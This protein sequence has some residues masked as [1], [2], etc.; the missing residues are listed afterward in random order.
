M[1]HAL[2]RVARAWLGVAYD[3]DVQAPARFP[4]VAAVP[5]RPLYEAVT[6]V[7]NFAAALTG[8]VLL[9]PLLLLIA[10]AVK[11][12][13][14]GPALYRG[15][16]VGKDQRVFHIFKFRTM[17]VDAEKRIGKRLVR[18]D[19]NHYTPIGRFLRKYRLDELAQLF[20]VLKGDMN[21][22]G[23]RPMRPIFLEDL[24]KTVPGYAK[25]FAVRPGITGLAQVR[26]GYYTHPRH[27][28]F[29]DV[30]YIAG[31]SVWVDLQ[32][33][34]LTFL[35]V[36]TRIFT[37][38]FLL[39]WLV[40]MALVLPA[41]VQQQFVLRVAKVEL[42][43]LYFVPTLIAVWHVV[44]R[45]VT[46]G[47]LYALRTPLD[48]PLL[49]FVLVTA[50]LVPFSRFPMASLRGLVWYV[51]NGVVVFYVVLNSSLVRE[52]RDTL[53]STL[54]GAT[55][56]MGAIA[57]ARMLYT[58][59]STGE[60]VR[61]AGTIGNPLLLAGLVVLVTPLAAA[62]LRRAT[63][64]RRRALYL[65]MFLPLL[66]TGVLT[67]SRSG[68]LALALGLG[69]YFAR[70]R[71]RVVA[72]IAGLWLA[73]TVAMSFAGDKRLQPSQAV[74]DLQR[75]VEVQMQVLHRLTATRLVVGTGARTLPS[76]VAAAAYA[77]D[78]TSALRG[79][80]ISLENTYLTVL[81]DHG[82]AGLLFFGAF[83]FGGLAFMYRSARRITDPAAA[84]DV[85]A[86]AAGL[87]AFAFLMLFSDALYRF[88]LMLMFWAA[89]GLGI[90]TALTHLPGPRTY[91]RLIHYRHQ[92]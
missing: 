64:P 27:K 20:N 77:A 65:A 45:E 62:R 53:V 43:V 52:K 14:P 83:L 58:V 71:W 72:A 26:G 34:A 51:C 57:I 85:W 19:E 59:H 28:L 17:Q 86:T 25:R 29:Y 84:D 31:R 35:R 36:M 89:M 87:T 38:G 61:L 90:G 75:R 91:Y 22:V 63:L 73:F 21:L 24:L 30:L 11:L 78:P 4:A 69:V 9:S 54:V 15:A 67:L 3:R 76:H 88:P 23:P 46:D 60:L 39:A 74:A 6:R 79:V 1:L 56:A 81:A 37:T 7:Y 92:L 33:I 32:L 42:N 18:Q 5:D 49:G 10:A 55:A 40:L 44:R 12:T 47:R 2:S 68:I 8:I 13:S 70:G 16:R 82:V 80:P 41:D 48:L 50:L 66:A